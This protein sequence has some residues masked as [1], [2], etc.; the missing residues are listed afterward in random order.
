MADE[1]VVLDLWLSMHGMRV[2]IPLADEGIQYEYK[3]QDLTNKSEL[4]LKMNP[5][6][7]KMPVLITTGNRSASRSS[8]FS[9][10][11]RYGETDLHCYSLILTR[12]LNPGFGLISLT[13]RYIL[14]ICLLFFLLFFF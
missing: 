11:I 4:L 7:K 2:R 6:H 8:S 13:R 9:T 14:A 12:D 3:E 1:V 5:L 10:S